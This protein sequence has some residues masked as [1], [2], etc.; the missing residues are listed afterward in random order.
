MYI[1]LFPWAIGL[2]VSNLSEAI[3]AAKSGGFQGVEFNPDEVADLIDQHGAAFVTDQFADADIRPAAFF[4]PTDWRTS[5][6]NFRESLKALP[7]QAEAA[8]KIGCLRTITWIVSGDNHRPL[9]EN[10][11]F[12]VERFAP[13]A[14]IFADYGIRIGLEFI[15]PKTFRDTFAH[16]FLYTM[17]DM[18]ALGRE[19]GSNVGLLLD[20]WHWYTSHGT[21]DDLKRLKAEQVVYVH[22]NDAPAGIPVDEQQD[23]VRALPG[24]TGVIDIVGFLRTLRAIGYD[25]PVTPE[26]FKKELNDLPSDEARLQAAG[27][28]TR[29]IFQRAGI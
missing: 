2:N 12:H 6:E 25:G 16:P 29:K 10:R 21:L 8:A 27:D 22:V 23:L 18:L 15:G 19:M 13:M 11:R 4:V 20:C 9:E 17:D 1:A 5:D 14:R 7:R 26:P 3:Q 28:A 24:E